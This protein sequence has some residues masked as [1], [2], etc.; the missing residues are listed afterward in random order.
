VQTITTTASVGM[1][2]TKEVNIRTDRMSGKYQVNLLVLF[3]AMN[4]TN[5]FP[6]LLYHAPSRRM[7]VM[8]QT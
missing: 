6:R 1:A 2:Q 3:C 7:I 4:E 8:L 5:L